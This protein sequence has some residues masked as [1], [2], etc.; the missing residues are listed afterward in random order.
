MV[1]LQE[2]S[3]LVTQPKRLWF[4]GHIRIFLYAV[5]IQLQKTHPMPDYS[6]LCMEIK[7]AFQSD[8]IEKRL[9]LFS[10]L[11]LQSN[12]AYNVH[13]NLKGKF[14]CLNSMEFDYNNMWDKK[15]DGR[16]V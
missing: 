11:L 2:T 5:Q 8:W 3:Y 15:I 9:K 12:E 14:I 6:A 13:T 4:E 1:L 10:Q 7:K 16:C